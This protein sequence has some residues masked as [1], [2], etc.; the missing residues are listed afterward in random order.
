[1]A[2]NTLT[3]VSATYATSGYKFGTACLNGGYATM[4]GH[5]VT[6]YPFTLECFFNAGTVAPSSSQ[7]ILG[8]NGFGYIGITTIGKLI[9]EIGTGTAVGGGSVGPQDFTTSGTV[10]DGN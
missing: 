6:G 2:G 9:I 10:I 1:M 7:V 4:P 5:T 8:G 3:S